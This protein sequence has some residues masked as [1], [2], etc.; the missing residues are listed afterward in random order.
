M[1]DLGAGQ[2]AKVTA[3]PQTGMPE[4]WAPWLFFKA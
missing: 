3:R 1:V 4:Y 2:C